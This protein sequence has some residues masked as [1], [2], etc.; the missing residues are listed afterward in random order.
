M[1]NATQ[2]LDKTRS[3][4]TV[5]FN[6]IETYSTL[7]RERSITFATS[8]SDEE[9]FQTQY[10][11]WRARKQSMIQADLEAQ[12][13]YMS[14]SFAQATLCGSV[15]QLAAKAIE[16]Y[17]CNTQI[18][19]DWASFIKPGTNQVLFCAGKLVREVPLGLVIYAARNQHTHFNDQKLRQPS[20]EV[21]H[22]LSTNHGYGK[23]SLETFRDPSFDLEIPNKTSFA[24]N[25][26]RLIG[27]RSL[28]E[29]ESD[30]K[31]LLAIYPY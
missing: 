23:E 13:H 2:Y 6:G 25:I 18:P 20:C 3:A 12:R 24:S 27:W 7:L 4:A 8:Y 31:Q 19:K 10:G 30:M 21:F 28:T 16:C 9:D 11:A 5:L 26:T 14:E 15:L 22:R 29:Y 17:S 1:Q